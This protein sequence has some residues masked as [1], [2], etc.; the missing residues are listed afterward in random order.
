MSYAPTQRA[1]VDLESLLGD[2][3]STQSAAWKLLSS[4]S[5][6]VNPFETIENEEGSRLSTFEQE[7]DELEEVSTNG[8]NEGM[9]I[10][11]L[12]SLRLTLP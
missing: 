2:G 6:S 9:F 12:F 10:P 7:F 5:E 1:G 8:G 11:Y 3:L 4:Q